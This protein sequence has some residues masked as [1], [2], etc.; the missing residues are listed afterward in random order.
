MAN[1][2]SSLDWEEAF[3]NQLK[4]FCAREQNFLTRPIPN[5]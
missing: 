5:E 2:Q 1:D 4:Y 3:R